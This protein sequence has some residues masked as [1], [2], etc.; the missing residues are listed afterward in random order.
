[1]KTRGIIGKRIV[2]IRQV[3]YQDAVRGLVIGVDAIV[4]EDGT[5]LRP[6]A[7]ETEDSDYPVDM[8]V[9]KSTPKPADKPR[10]R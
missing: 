8:L 7:H 2:A 3:R 6:F 9:I 5:E 10:K 1:V 4:L